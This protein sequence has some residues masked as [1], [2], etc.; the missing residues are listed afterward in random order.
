MPLSGAEDR[1]FRL[2]ELLAIE[3]RLGE[4]REYLTRELEPGALQTVKAQLDRLEAAAKT[5]GRVTWAQ[6][7]IGAV[8]RSSG[9]D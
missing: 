3:T 8:L 7:A 1:P 5:A 6:M 9:A 2:E 4:V